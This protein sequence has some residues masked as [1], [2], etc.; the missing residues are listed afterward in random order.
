MKHATS[1]TLIAAVAAATALLFV[2][3]P[4]SSA[5]LTD[6]STLQPSLQQHL[7]TVSTTTPVRVM[8]QAGGSISA[9]RQAVE[10]AGLRLETTLDRAGIAV[11]V[12]APVS[13]NQLGGASGVTRVD[14]ADEQLRLFTETSHTATRAVPVQDGAFDVVGSSAGDAFD[15]SGLSVAVIDTGVD[16]THPMFQQGGESRV[17]KNVKVV[18]N[19]ALPI[20]IGDATP[21]EACTVDATAV[22]DTDTT[23]AGGHGTHAAGIAAGGRVVDRAG[24]HLRGAAPGADLVGVSIGAGATTFA[25]SIGM[26]WVLEHHADPCGDGSCAPIV[27]VNNSWGGQ[28]DAFDPT[29]P[30]AVVQRLLVADGVTVVWAAGNAGGNGTTIEVNPYSLDPTPGVLSIANYDDLDT[31]TRDNDLAPGSSRGL[32]S[33]RSTYPDLS[34]PGTRITSACR[35]YL[36][37]CAAGGDTDDPDYN[38]LTGTSM[39]APHI[40]GYVAVLQQAALATTGQLLTPGA[41][42]D[43][44]LDTAHHF[45]SRTWV[46]DTRNP[47]STTGTSFDAGHGLVDVT[48]ALATLT[49]RSLVVPPTTCPADSRFT[50]P[51]GDAVGISGVPSPTPNEPG[52]DLTAAWLT[53]NAVT[54][55]VTF[56]WTVGDL[57]E[58]AGGAEGDGESFDFG[59]TFDGD[60]YVLRVTRTLTRGQTF[61]LLT[62]GSQTLANN[63]AGSFNTTTDEV[64]VTLPAGLI[65]TKVPG[66]QVINT[67]DQISS[68]TIVSKRD[69]LLT[70]VTD[71]ADG[72]CAYTVGG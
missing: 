54:D 38:T 17:R 22:N 57:P 3:T 34:A 15:G 10:S 67:G 52:L 60:G 20:L 40:T 30:Q 33:D 63:L 44:I 9:A 58:L 37:I 28:G 24:R 6:G 4:P 48:A 56:H 53:T 35:A 21:V 18:C 41:V 16:G 1:K 19:D 70:S 50:D 23:S 66:A 8:V 29:A 32:A 39:A 64:K 25:G 42:E 71:E 55:D 62:S 2:G 59:F 31:G 11:A 27:A 65:A 12:G 13:I 72:S 69:V 61:S 51:E 45:G 49:G 46:T 43:L 26:Y 68:L 14:W 5:G 36:V 7:A 47:D